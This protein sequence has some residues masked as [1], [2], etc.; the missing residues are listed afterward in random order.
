MYQRK[1]SDLLTTLHA[2]LLPLYLGQLKNLHKT[3]AAQYAKDLTTGLKEPGYDFGNVVAKATTKAREAFA[4]GAGGEWRNGP[5]GRALTRL[6]ESKVDGTDW[7]DEQELLALEEDLK[8]IADRLR[9][10]ETKKMV[11]AIEVSTLTRFC[12]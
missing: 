8:I 3:V 12:R 4:A 6:A 1:R 11:N 7:T 9:A 5:D 2:T 10:D